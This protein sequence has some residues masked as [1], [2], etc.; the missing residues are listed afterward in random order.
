VTTGS[1]TLFASAGLLWCT[2]IAGSMAGHIA[3]PRW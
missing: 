1:H 3:Y 2:L